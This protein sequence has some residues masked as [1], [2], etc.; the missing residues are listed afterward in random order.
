MISHISND[1]AARDD[2]DKLTLTSPI[3]FIP[4][5]QFDAEVLDLLNRAQSLIQQLA[6]AEETPSDM[7][8]HLARMCSAPLLSPQQEVTLFREMNRLKFC[9]ESMRR[10][11]D[12][13][14][15]SD[16]WKNRSKSD[17]LRTTELLVRSPS[18]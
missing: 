18:R 17:R 13:E 1:L 9:A 5:E 6:E 15:T 12:D 8:A 10:A 4:N 3:D 11:N 16:N 2:V 14:T 7:P